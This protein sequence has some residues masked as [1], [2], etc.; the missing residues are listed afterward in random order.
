[1]NLGTMLT[2]VTNDKFVEHLI[3]FWDYD[4]GSLVLW[5]ASS[6]FVYAFE[7]QQIPYFLRISFSPNHCT[8]QIEA[9]LAFIDYLHANGYPS[10]TPTPSKNKNFIETWAGPDGTYCA[11]VFNAAKGE[12]LD[13][14]EITE[15]EM[16]EL[17]KSLARLHSLSATYQPLHGK[18]KSWL[19]TIQY[20]EQIFRKK[21]DGLVA[22]QELTYLTDWL[23]TLPMDNHLYGLLHYDFQLDNVFYEKGA[24]GTFQVIDF[25]DSI[26]H[27]YALDVVIA[28]DDFMNADDPQSIVRTEAFLN[29]YRTYMP[30]ENHVIAQFPMFIRYANLYKFARLLDALDYDVVD[31]PPDWFSD[32][33]RKFIQVKNNL[34]VTFTD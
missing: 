13:E 3:E 14:D 33:N 29:G 11:V 21:A 27:W 23:H 17:G 25:D 1:M 20:M 5:R 2:G 22:L 15:N 28:L 9:E 18:R 31:N 12:T 4:E 8:E 34:K 10:I 6:N 32:L 26:Y 30:L 7:H 24:P 19:H 16:N